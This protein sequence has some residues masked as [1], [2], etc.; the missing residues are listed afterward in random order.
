MQKPQAKGGPGFAFVRAEVWS[1]VGDG[2]RRP[3]AFFRI[4][5]QRS[6]K[7]SRR[8]LA[9]ALPP[10][11]VPGDE[12]KRVSCPGG[13]GMESFAPAGHGALLVAAVGDRRD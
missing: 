8:A 7:R 2:E 9:A 12:E 10:G 3:C 6:S 1:C 11:A 13:K 4:A 5:M